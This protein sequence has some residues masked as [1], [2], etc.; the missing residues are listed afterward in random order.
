MRGVMMKNSKSSVKFREK[1]V[2]RRDFLTRAAVAMAGITIIPRHVLGGA[3]YTPP[4]DK[5]NIAGVGI[6]GMGK[7]NVAALAT[8][9]N[10]VALCDV[11]DNYA[12]EIF[13]KYPG[14]KKYRDFRKMLE[15]EKSIDAVV[16]ATPDHTHA[17]ISLAA[18]QLGK[19]VYCQKPLTHSIYEAR[20]LAEAA[21]DAGV[22]TQM[23][24]Q[25][26][27]GEGNRL[28][29][30]WI[31]DGAIGQ[32][33]EVHAWTNRPA[34]YWPQGIGR[35]ED[36]PSLPVGLGWNL[37]LG[38]AP[39]RPYNPAYA[40]FKWR[41]WWDFGTGALGDMGCHI[42]DTPFWAL[43]LGHPTSVDASSSP[44][45]GETYPLASIVHYTFPA[46]GDMPPV[47]LTWYDGGLM[48]P[49]PEELEEGRKMGDRGGGVLFVGEKG[50][51][52]CGVYGNN[53]R[54]IPETR[55]QEYEQPAKSIPRVEGI[56]E[57]WIQA[58][59]GGKPACSNFD[60]SGPLTEMV[61]LGNIALRTGEKI[62][63]DGP[64]MRVTNIDEAN[65]Y[66]DRDYREGWSL[67][68]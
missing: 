55:M 42:I 52:M 1:D 50:K 36:A 47:K 28:I 45:N 8:T 49:R 12:L 37:W 14:A 39:Y 56:H 6:G 18:I 51:L 11:D 67:S 66:V 21:R 58:S 65:Q 10:I 19:H 60:I 46:R 35:P 4:S 31:W 54:L 64:N 16:V 44:V 53:P 63:W 40:P 2:S 32:V 15:N 57:D 62:T 68:S 59:K 27:A 34:G 17:V 22:A 25:G 48:P 23:G 13:K 30:E 41:G 5:L 9:E 38:P 61:L 20:N 24:N 3:G 7:N 43:K 29:A 26:H 33:R